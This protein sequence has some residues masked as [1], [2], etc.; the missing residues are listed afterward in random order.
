MGADFSAT[1]RPQRREPQAASPEGGGDLECGEDRRFGIF[2]GACSAAKNKGKRRSS[3]HSRSGAASRVRGVFQKVKL[4][5]LLPAQRGP[6]AGVFQHA[7]LVM[8]HP[9]VP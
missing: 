5:A 2:S 7:F 8:P 3:T 6:V 1:R 4:E 9:V